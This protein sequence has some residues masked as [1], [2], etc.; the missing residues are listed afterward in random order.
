VSPP[1]G[2]LDIFYTDEG[3][4]WLLYCGPGI[5]ARTATPS[6]YVIVTFRDDFGVSGS[7]G[8]AIESFS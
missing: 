5:A 3:A 8:F 6:L 7:M 4:N 2:T 1:L